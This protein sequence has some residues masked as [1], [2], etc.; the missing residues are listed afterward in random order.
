MT[1]SI[2]HCGFTEMFLESSDDYEPYGC[3][4]ESAYYEETVNSTKIY[5]SDKRELSF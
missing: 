4:D 5:A 3:S 1:N 2:N